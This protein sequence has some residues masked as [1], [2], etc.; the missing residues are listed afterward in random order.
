MALALQGLLRDPSSGS[1]SASAVIQC[2]RTS[3]LTLMTHF[4]DEYA[5]VVARHRAYRTALRDEVF[6]MRRDDLR[7]SVAVCVSEGVYP[8]KQ[9]VF[10]GAALSSTFQRLPEYVQIWRDALREHGIQ[11]A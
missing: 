7:D 5:Q 4:P 3:R 10:A 11:R 8:S 9:R 6:E 2:L 1:L